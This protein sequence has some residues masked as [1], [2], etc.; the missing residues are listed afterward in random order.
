M[1]GW[2]D[3]DNSG[4]TCTSLFIDIDYRHLEIGLFGKTQN[5]LRI[6]LIH[7]F[8]N[9]VFEKSAIVLSGCIMDKRKC[10]VCFN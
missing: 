3:L 7:L 8:A 5:A 6:L 10:N 1:G 9:V 4:T 2:R